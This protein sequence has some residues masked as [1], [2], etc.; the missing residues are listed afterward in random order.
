MGDKS[1]GMGRAAHSF[2]YSG[3]RAK[4][5]RTQRKLQSSSS[6]LNGKGPAEGRKVMFTWHQ[7]PVCF[8]MA[9]QLCRSFYTHPL[10]EVRSQQGPKGK[11][12]SR[13]QRLVSGSSSSWALRAETGF[14]FA[15]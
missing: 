7:T 3:I 6:N 1:P 5:T 9:R 4:K 11:D 8:Q 13:A 2:Q 12:R 10:R 15:K 14:L